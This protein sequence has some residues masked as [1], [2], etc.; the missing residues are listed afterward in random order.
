MKRQVRV[1]VRVRV[2][3]SVLGLEGARVSRVANPNPNLSRTP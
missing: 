3:V 2:R 1:R